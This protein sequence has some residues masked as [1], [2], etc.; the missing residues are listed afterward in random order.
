MK[1][2]ATIGCA[3]LIGITLLTLA[4][5]TLAHAGVGASAPMAASYDL[6]WWSFDGGGYI[7]SSGGDYEL[8]GTIGQ[9]DAWRGRTTGD[10]SLG[11]GFWSCGP[12]RYDIYLPLALNWY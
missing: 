5:G 8:G 9:P 7:F 12:A 3:L 10:Y 11:T 4:G 1:N 6:S 2:L